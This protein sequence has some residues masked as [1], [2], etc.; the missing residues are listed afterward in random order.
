MNA[1][2]V[3]YVSLSGVLLLFKYMLFLF[4]LL[5]MLGI[6]TVFEC[7]YCVSLNRSILS[8]FCLFCQEI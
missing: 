7:Q 5:D 3:R 2:S 4:L 6:N 1:R 8:T